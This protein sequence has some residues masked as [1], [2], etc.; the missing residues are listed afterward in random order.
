M[1]KKLNWV[2]NWCQNI[3]GSKFLVDHTA[4]FERLDG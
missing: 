4:G 3:F 2:L 1:N